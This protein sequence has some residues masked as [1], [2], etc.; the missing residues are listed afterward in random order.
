MKRL[1]VLFVVTAAMALSGCTLTRNHNLITSVPVNNNPTAA[2]T[3]TVELTRPV[4]EQGRPSQTIEPSGLTAAADD[5]SRSADDLS[6]S[7]D[8]LLKDLD[9]MDTL[10]DVK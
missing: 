2:V 5:V 1:I 4:G 3:L 7:L 8:S 10:N 6:N 9:T